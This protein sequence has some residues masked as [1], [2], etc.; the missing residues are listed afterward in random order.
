MTIETI[1]KQHLPAY[2]DLDFSLP[3][4]VSHR[5]VT[6]NTALTKYGAIEN[7]I[8]LLTE[9]IVQI[10]IVKGEEERILEFVFPGAFFC[11]YTSFL[12][13]QPSD[14]QVTT[15]T[16]CSVSIIQKE[17][18]LQA[19]QASLLSSHLSLHI[20]QQLFLSRAKREKDFLI[21]SA[22]ERY[23]ALLEK[24]ANIV[25]HIPGNKIASYLGIRAE[26]LSRIRKAIIP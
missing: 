4:E 23:K 3:F 9:G 8:F 26:S 1:I 7:K 25:K 16:T 24:D 21:L 19:N 17:S 14:V 10:S 13:Q 22:E 15:L 11:A 12:L 20:A 5:S 18:L 2:K 6:A